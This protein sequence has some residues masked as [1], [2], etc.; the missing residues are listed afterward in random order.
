M[1]D[2]EDCTDGVKVFH[3]RAAVTQNARSP[4]VECTV[5]GTISS[6]VDAERN[7]C[8]YV[9]LVK[10]NYL[11]LLFSSSYVMLYRYGEV[12][13]NIYRSTGIG[14]VRM[15]RNVRHPQR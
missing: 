3:A 5:R 1:S 7:R 12:K 6:D 13:M 8:P 10:L 15:E 9:H 14:F 2:S 4:I 11:L